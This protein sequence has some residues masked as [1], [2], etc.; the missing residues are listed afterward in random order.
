M[1]KDKPK[2]IFDE[3]NCDRKFL[4]QGGNGAE[5]VD[6]T[7]DTLVCHRCKKDVGRT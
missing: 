4:Y 2:Y 6:S 5:R 7:R 3:T 1:E